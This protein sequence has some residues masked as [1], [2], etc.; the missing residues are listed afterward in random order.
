MSSIS[1]VFEHRLIIECDGFQHADDPRDVRRDDW[2]RAQ[3]FA[4]VRFWNH[5]IM[6][7]RE[8]VLNTILSRC[9]LQW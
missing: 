7:E 5:E 4:V 9:D 6:H 1:F 3:G 8:N 2:L